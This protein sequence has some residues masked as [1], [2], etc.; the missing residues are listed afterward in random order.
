MITEIPQYRVERASPSIGYNERRQEGH[1]S[2]NA[3]AG[4]TAA[5]RR[6]GM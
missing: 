1:P 4:S 5:A 3:T 6:V 2:L